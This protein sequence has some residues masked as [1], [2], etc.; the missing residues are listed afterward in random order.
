MQND[1]VKRSTTLR[2]KHEGIEPD[3]VTHRYHG[4]E[5]AYAAGVLSVHRL[6]LL[7][8]PYTGSVS[9]NV[10]R[11]IKRVSVAIL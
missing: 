2:Q 9:R 4:L 10:V 5:A 3:A 6:H 11:Y 8:P 7:L 1:R